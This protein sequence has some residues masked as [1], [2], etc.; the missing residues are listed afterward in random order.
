M[1]E[2]SSEGEGQLGERQFCSVRIFQFSLHESAVNT[3]IL[4]TAL[5]AMMEFIVTVLILFAMDQELAFKVS[6]LILVL[7]RIHHF[8]IHSF[9]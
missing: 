6:M 2:P 1:S 8:I 9:V 4:I 5:T 3:V 7:V